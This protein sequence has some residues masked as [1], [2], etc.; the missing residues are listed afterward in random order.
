MYERFQMPVLAVE[1]FQGSRHPRRLLLLPLYASL[2]LDL[3]LHTAKSPSDHS[4]YI[5]ILN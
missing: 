4:I 2:D 1:S 3:S 5:Y